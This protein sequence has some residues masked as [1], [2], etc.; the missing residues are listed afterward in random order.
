VPTG[1]YT[2]TIAVT[3]DGALTWQIP[4]HLRVCDFTLPDP[5]NARAMLF[6]SVDK[7]N[8][9]YL[10]QMYP[11]PGTAVYTQSLALADRHFQLAHRPLSS[12]GRR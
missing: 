3:E 6:Y 11:A 10:G 4:I 8:N 7:V 12:P 1:I 5:P 9:R 2:G